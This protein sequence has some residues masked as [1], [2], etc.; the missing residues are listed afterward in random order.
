MNKECKKRTLKYSGGSNLFKYSRVAIIVH[1]YP[2]SQRNQM[3]ML[4]LLKLGGLKE[5]PC[6]ALTQTSEEGVLAG[7]CWFSDL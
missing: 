5:G 6:R 7:W 1:T 3:K 4:K 2:Y